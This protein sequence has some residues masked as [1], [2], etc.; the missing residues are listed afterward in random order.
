MIED[1]K[2]SEWY[3]KNK[4]PDNN[5]IL[6]IF[7]LEYA[8]LRLGNEDDLYVTRFGLPF[9]ENLHP[10]NF[11][12]DKTWFD[13]NS[14]RLSGTS[15]LYKVTTKEVDG[16]Q[17]E[18]VMKWNRMGQ[19]IP[20][21]YDDYCSEE[22]AYAEFNSPFEEFSLVMEL[23]NALY[24]SGKKIIIQTPLAIYVPAKAVELWKSGRKEYKMRSKIDSHKEIELDMLRSYAVIYGWIKG[25]DAV[26]ACK[27]GILDEKYMSLLTLDSE[28]RLEKS[29]FIVRDSKPHHIIVMPKDR[30]LAKDKN[31]NILYALVDFELLERTPEREEIVK[32]DKRAEYLKRQK[33]RFSITIPEKFPSH[34]HYV[35]IFGVDYAYGHVESTKGRLWVVGRDPNLFEYFLPEKWEQ[36]QK[37]KISV[38]EEMYYTLTKDNIHLAWKISKVG[39]QPDMDPFRAE[40]KKILEY[41]YNSPFEEVAI[42]VELSRKGIASIYPRAIYMTSNKSYISDSFFDN[43]RYESHKDIL[44]PDGT[45]I[46][47]YDRDYIIIWGYWNGPDERLVA[48]D[49]DFYEGINVLRA[50]RKGIITQAQYFELLQRAKEELYKVDIEDLNLR[51]NHLLI[52]VDSTGTLISDTQGRIELRVCNF[53]FLKRI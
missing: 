2:I 4:N 6:K 52:S 20:G 14:T 24:S 13:Q 40:E 10:K 21:E 3:Y 47:R 7:G 33:D 46:L 18:I 11:L 49:G 45:P 51:G 30:D 34:L 36:I 1:N 23:R 31:K 27:E 9:I 37:T 5:E 48:K 50:Y 25:L 38:Y 8:H 35:N 28:S 41:G 32:K 43:S 15:C 22:L 16:K 12:T 19:E 53:E 42:A 39:L 26:Q 44:N 17:K 29:G